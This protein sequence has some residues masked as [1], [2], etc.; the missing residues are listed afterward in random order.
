MGI[1]T[2]EATYVGPTPN[3]GGS[4]L[5]QRGLVLHVMQGT[6]AGSVSWG[7]NPASSMSFHFGTRKSDGLVQQLVDTSIAAWTQCNGNGRWISVENEDYSGNPLSD[8]QIES[9]ARLYARGHREYSWPFQIADSPNGRGLGWHGMGGVDWCNHPTCPGEPIKQQRPA[10]LARA[11][12]IV[13]GGSTPVQQLEG[14]D[15]LIAKSGAGP[16]GEDTDH[17]RWWCGT[18]VHFVEITKAEA[19]TRIHALR[20]F[21]GAPNATILTWGDSSPEA[22]QRNIGPVAAGTAPGGGPVPLTYDQTVQA[23]RDG[24]NLAEDS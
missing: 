16:N 21:Y 22:V 15:M 13:N 14:A 23:A 17:S 9:I 12:Q 2:P 3:K 10:I 5:E 20:N 18:G 11:E 8:A 7:K 4:M 19:D 6:L 1:W 24:A